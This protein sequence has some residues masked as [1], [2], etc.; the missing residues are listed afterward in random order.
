MTEYC[1][2]QGWEYEICEDAGISGETIDGRPGMLRLL[3]L[4][5]TGKI[6][7]ALAVEM[8]RFSRSTD[9]ED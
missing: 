1:E 7:V 8:E 9:L 2:R 3:E 4:A 5:R 6:Q